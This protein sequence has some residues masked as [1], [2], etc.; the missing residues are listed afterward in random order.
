MLERWLDDTDVCE[1]TVSFNFPGAPV[2]GGLPRIPAEPAPAG[3]DPGRTIYTVEVRDAAVLACMQI[4]AMDYRKHF[5]SIVM[6]ELRG[7]LPRTIAGPKSSDAAREAR[8][9]AW[10]NTVSAAANRPVPPQ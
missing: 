8:I 6:H 1:E 5:P 2:P 4:S 7:Y 3:G 9:E 10:R